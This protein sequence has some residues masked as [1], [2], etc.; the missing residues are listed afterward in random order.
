MLHRGHIDY[1]AR[2]RSLGDLLIVG[3]NS[4]DGVRRLKGPDRPLNS[5]EDRAAV[6]SALAC[7][8]HVVAFDEDLPT[9]LVGRLRPDIFVKGGDY[10]VDRLP[11]APLVRQLGGQV[12]ILPYL[13]DRSTS[14]IVDRLRRSVAV[15]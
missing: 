2:A 13:P 12:H 1:L 3:L 5:L 15:G 9:E 6:L 10:T 11:E 14:A 8:D 7:V 4:D